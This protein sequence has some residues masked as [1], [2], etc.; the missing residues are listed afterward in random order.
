ML[1]M[2]KKLLFS[3]IGL[4]FMQMKPDL[5]K[6]LNSNVDLVSSNGLSKYLKP[7]VDQEKQIIY[8][9]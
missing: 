4:Q 9:R 8:A 7:I 6:R 1:K 5:E 3:V 2:K